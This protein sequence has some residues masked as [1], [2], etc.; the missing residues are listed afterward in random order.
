MPEYSRQSL[1]QA[2]D[3]VRHAR[4]ELARTAEA[5]NEHGASRLGALCELRAAEQD[6]I[7]AE[8]LREDAKLQYKASALPEAG[9]GPAGERRGG[10]AGA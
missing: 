10:V 2:I 4:D 6:R 3:A 9:A 5:L 7:L 8:L 1:K